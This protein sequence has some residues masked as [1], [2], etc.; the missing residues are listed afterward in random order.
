MAAAEKYV[1][2]NYGYW[3]ASL[4]AVALAEVAAAE[5]MP[6]SGTDAAALYAAIGKGLSHGKYHNRF[7]IYKKKELFSSKEKSDAEAGMLADMSSDLD[8]ATAG[9]TAEKGFSE[10]YRS[11]GYRSD[12]E[13]PYVYNM[14][15]A[16]KTFMQLRDSQGKPDG[17]YREYGALA[18]Y[19]M[20]K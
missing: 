10:Y 6:G 12:S 13:N 7:R 8:A 19:Q 16:D 4:T 3:K 15:S 11:A 5:G 17:T 14:I 20:V 2:A 9:G 18:V 1:A